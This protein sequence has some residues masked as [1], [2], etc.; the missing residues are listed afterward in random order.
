[1]ELPV[2]ITNQDK[3]K[4]GYNGRNLAVY[5]CEFVEMLRHCEGFVVRKLFKIKQKPQH[6]TLIFY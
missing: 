2:F 3:T 1:M 4:F 6:R 5:S